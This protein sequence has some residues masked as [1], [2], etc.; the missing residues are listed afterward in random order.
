MV[1]M[2]PTK[3]QTVAENKLREHDMVQYIRVD[4]ATLQR[5]ACG[6]RE[7]CSGSISSLCIC[8]NGSPLSRGV[9]FLFNVPSSFLLSCFS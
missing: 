8:Y 3:L 7:R 2:R 5:D 4:Y 9:L 1:A 6:A